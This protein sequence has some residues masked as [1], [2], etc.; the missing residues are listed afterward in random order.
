MIYRLIAEAGNDKNQRNRIKSVIAMGET[1]DKGA[2]RTLEEFCARSGMRPPHN[3]LCI[4]HSV[5]V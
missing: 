4:R 1:A 3:K 5:A 2:V